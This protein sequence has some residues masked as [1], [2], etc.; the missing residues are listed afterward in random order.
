M[1]LFYTIVGSVGVAMSIFQAIPYVVAVLT[2]AP[3]EE[4]ALGAIICGLY[5]LLA[6]VAFGQVDRLERKVTEG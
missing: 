6:T 3:F 4:R 1:K 5:L 2:G